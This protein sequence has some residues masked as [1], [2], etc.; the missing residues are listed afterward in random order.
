MGVE[1]IRVA[2]SFHAQ[3]LFMQEKMATVL[4]DANGRNA[5]GRQVDGVLDKNKV[6]S[7]LM[8]QIGRS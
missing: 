4:K 1:S 8:M 3:P 5:G 6:C 7:P 2:I